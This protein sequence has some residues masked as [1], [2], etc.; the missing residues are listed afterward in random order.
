MRLIA[1][2]SKLP[3]VVLVSLL[4]LLGCSEA[5]NESIIRMNAGVEAAQSQS[6]AKAEKEFETA[7]TLDPEN[8]RAAYSLGLVRTEQKKWDRAVDAFTTAVKFNDKDAMYHYHLGR[9]YYELGKLDMA[10]PEL[11]KA[12][13]LNKRLYK[14]YFF[15]GKVHSQQDRPKEAAVAWTESCRLNPTFGKPFVELGKLYYGWDLFQEAIQV[16]AQGAE[17]AR[18]SEDTTDI[19]YFLGLAHDALKQYDRAVVAYS[20][21]LEERKDNHDARLQLGFA[22]AN[23]GEKVKARKSLEDY[24]KLAGSSNPFALQAANDRILKLSG[25]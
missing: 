22:Y 19:F 18:D 24:V 4:P 14:A 20:K 23:L 10:R 11:E 15:L 17:N 5:R 1:S 8:H 21:A 25:E 16:L 6:Y 9:A 12:I 7:I 13:Q 3:T 2:S